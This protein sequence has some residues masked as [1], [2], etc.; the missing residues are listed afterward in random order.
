MERL[1]DA[2]EDE[3]IARNVIKARI[4]KYEQQ[5]EAISAE[6]DEIDRQLNS[7]PSEELRREKAKSMR[8]TWQKFNIRRKYSSYK[9]F[10]EMP[11]EDKR[12]LIRKLFDGDDPE[13]NP[14]GVYV[15][16]E[17]G[18]WNYTIKGIAVD[19]SDELGMSTYEANI[20]LAVPTIL[21]VIEDGKAHKDIKPEHLS[22]I[23]EWL[24]KHGG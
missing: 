9:H 6:I 5:E 2:I 23:Q 15:A 1:V 8:T 19:I 24:K 11:F 3:T 16:K 4:N 21:D 17:E 13:G 14:L 10:L 18:I 22:T 7:F 12:A 20:L